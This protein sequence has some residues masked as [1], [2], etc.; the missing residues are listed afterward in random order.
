M[1][2]TRLQLAC[3]PPSV[4]H[5]WRHTK[6]GTYRTADYMAWQ[7]GEGH[8]LNRQLAGQHKFTGPVYITLAMTRPRSNADIDN[9]IKGVLDLLAKHGAIANDKCVMGVNAFWSA[10][11]P[12]GVA[13]EVSIV[14][15]GALESA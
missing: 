7:N 13:A 6:G 3:L 1:L 12:K 2:K 4:N 10:D 11:L 5:I 9:R 15:A 14:A 8:A